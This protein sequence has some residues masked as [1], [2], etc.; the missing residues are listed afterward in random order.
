MVGGGFRLGA[1]GSC[2]QAVMRLVDRRVVEVNTTGDND[3]VA[4]REGVC[5]PLVRGCARAGEND[6]PEVRTARAR[7]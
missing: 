5:A 4:G 7:R 2:C 3:D 1:S 6:N